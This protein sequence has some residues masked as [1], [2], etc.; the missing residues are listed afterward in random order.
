[1]ANSIAALKRVRQ[2]RTRTQRNKVISSRVKT[3]R[4]A[5]LAAIEAGDSDAAKKNYNQL[6]SAADKAARAN[7][8]HR[9]AAARIKSNLTSRINAM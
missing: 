8:I 9:N 7:V 2:I 6:A 1:M 4:K 5:T 3:Y